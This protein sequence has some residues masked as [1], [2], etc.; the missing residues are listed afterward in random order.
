MTC[1][2]KRRALSKVLGK[3]K[4]DYVQH[5]INGYRMKKKKKTARF[6]CG[7]GFLFIYVAKEAALP[8]PRSGVNGTRHF[9]HSHKRYSS[10]T[11]WHW[12]SHCKRSLDNYLTNINTFLLFFL[13]TLLWSKTITITVVCFSLI[14]HFFSNLQTPS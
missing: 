14:M 6:C 10:L 1:R 9:C 12:K 3:E 13:G 8:L 7:W 2:L 4:W 11:F 5:K